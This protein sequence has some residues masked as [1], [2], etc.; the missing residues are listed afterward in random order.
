MKNFNIEEVK[1]II[2]KSNKV[3][4]DYISNNKNLKSKII[5]IDTSNGYNINKILNVL[6]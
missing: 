2:K 4:F 6:N 3:I 5:R 1:Q